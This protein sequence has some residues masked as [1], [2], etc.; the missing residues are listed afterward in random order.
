MSSGN[1]VL[2]EETPITL[3]MLI[4]IKLCLDR[5]GS[6]ILQDTEFFMNIDPERVQVLNTDENAKL[7]RFARDWLKAAL[8]SEGGTDI[9]DMLKQC[10]LKDPHFEYKI[11]SGLDNRM[12]GFIFVTAEGKMLLENYGDIVFADF[13]ASGM[14]SLRWP[15][16]TLSVVDEENHSVVCVHCIVISECNEAY[17]MV[18]EKC[19]SWVPVMQQLTKVIRTDD[20]ASPQACHCIYQLF[21]WQACAT[22]TCV[23]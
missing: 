15:Y 8:N 17:E 19:V 21:T 11:F 5:M 4:N 7:Q 1:T 12:T 22:F 16:G 3:Q 6:K 18:L 14:S 23:K 20:L 9:Q 13:K 2:T 10:K